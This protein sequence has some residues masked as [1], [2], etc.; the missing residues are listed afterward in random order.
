[1]H[2]EL[3]EFV[4]PSESSLR[5][6]WESVLGRDVVPLGTRQ[7]KFV[8]CE[9]VLCLCASLLV[10]HRKYG[11]TSSDRAEFP[12][13]HFARLFK[14]RP[15]SFLAKMANLDGS[16]RNSGRNEVDVSIFLRS[17][18]ALMQSV[19]LRIIRS[20]RILGI[21]SEQL[22]DFLDL[23][24]GRELW[25][26]GQDELV[27]SEIEASLDQTLERWAVERDDLPLETTQR[28]LTST[29]RIGQHRFAER[30]LKTHDHRCVFCGMSGF[31]AGRRR[32]KMLVASHIKPWRDSSGK[33]RLDYRNGLTACPTHDVAFDTGLI[34]VETDLTVKYA[35]GVEDEIASQNAL[36]FALGRPPLAERL[37]L[38]ESAVRPDISYLSWHRTEVFVDY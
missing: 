7:V 21:D 14:R 29:V 13:Q 31:I 11:G 5:G 1:V 28:L 38:P 17:D 23:E 18:V 19:Y 26:E 33:E 22:P 3:A 32:P 6:Q 37:I 4:D 12:V 15:S 9:V 36:R 30:V 10:D 8:P 25:L 16:R 20:A 35:P 24:S 34:T 2:S 27:E